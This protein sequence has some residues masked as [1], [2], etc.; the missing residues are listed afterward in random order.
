LDFGLLFNTLV[1]LAF[2]PNRPVWLSRFTSNYV[3]VLTLPA[4]PILHREC[5]YAIPV[6]NTRDALLRIKQVFEEGNV[7]T[8]LPVEL[9][10]VAQD[11]TLL[12]PVNG[13]NVCYI[14]ANTQENATEVFQRFEPIMKTF[15]GRPHWGKHFTMTK[16]EMASMYP[17]TAAQFAQ[18]RNTWD[19]D[20]VLANTLIHQLFG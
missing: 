7:I 14:G 6:E 9:R 3:N 10:F 12:S 15:G 20:N 2:D 5:E 13:R 18:L 16:E 1:H 11:D 17:S 19:P 4:F 8:T